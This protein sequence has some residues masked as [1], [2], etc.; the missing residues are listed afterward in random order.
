MVNVVSVVKGN[1]GVESHHQS[2]IVDRRSSIV[3][4][5]RQ[6]AREDDRGGAGERARDEECRRQPLGKDVETHYDVDKLNQKESFR[7][8]KENYH[9]GPMLCRSAHASLK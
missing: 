9:L 6:E 1:S 3:G 5:R 7:Y 2:I 4:R 8:V